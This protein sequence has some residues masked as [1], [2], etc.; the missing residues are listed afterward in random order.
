MSKHTRQTKKPKDR[1]GI[2]IY[3][4]DKGLSLSGRS[5]LLTETEMQIHGTAQETHFK[6][7]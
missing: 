2:E 6:Q 5:I 1:S 7:V 3:H 4:M